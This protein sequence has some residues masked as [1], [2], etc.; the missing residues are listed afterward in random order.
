MLG[1]AS[2]WSLPGAA[3]VVALLWLC[4]WTL[5]WS[6]WTPRRLERALRAQGL[7]G[8]RYRLFIG[9]VAENGRLNG[10]A[11]SRPLPLGS[12][13]IV[14]RVIPFFCNVLKEH[15]KLSFIWTGPKPMVIITDP[16]LAR[17]VLSNKSGNFGKQTTAGISKFVI[18]GVVTYEGEKWAKHRRILNPAFHQEKLKRMLPVFSACC[19]EMITRW[20]NSITSEGLSEL[21]VRDEFQNLT[22]DVISRTA[23]GS[24]F[25]EGRRIFQLQEEQAKRVLQAFQR[26]FLPGYWYL[27]IKNNRRIREIDQEIRTILRGIIVKRDKAIRNGETSIDDLLGLLVESNMRESNER[28]YVGMS[29]EDMIEEC[30]LFYSA[31]SETTSVLLTWALILLSMHPEWQQRAR[32]EVLHHFGRTTPDHDGLSRLKIVTMILHEVLRLYPPVVFLQRRTH[33]ETE[34]GG[35]KYPKGAHFTLPVLF[36]QHDPSIWGQDASEFNPERFANGVSKATK[37]QAAFLPFAWGPRVCIGQSFAMLEAKMA[38]ATILRSFSFELSPS[39][40][41]AP[42]TVLTLQPQHGAQIKLK[43]LY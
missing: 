20:K 43:K 40:T 28:E 15:G 42:C 7:R 2:P 12:H 17:E 11:A 25:Q 31:G 23:F 5:Q 14:P 36:I 4:A 32:E 22:G 33:K 27:P 29:I 16:D 24:S 18:G 8:T 34:L 30:K 1:E 38:L 26:I 6:W 37:F 19:T 21:D 35:I 10:E 41:H 3:A 9:D 39:Y 13:D